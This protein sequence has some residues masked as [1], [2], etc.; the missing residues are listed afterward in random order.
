MSFLFAASHLPAVRARSPRADA[1]NDDDARTAEGARPL[2]RSGGVRACSHLPQGTGCFAFE[3]CSRDFVQRVL[4]A[5]RAEA[6][7]SPTAAALL[8]HVARLPGR[9]TVRPCAHGLSRT[10][11]DADGQVTL[12]L[13]PQRMTGATIS[14]ELGHVLQQAHAHAA[15]QQARRGGR[16]AQGRDYAAAMH[17]GRTALDAVVPVADARDAGPEHKENEAMRISNIVNAERTAS[18]MRSLP[19]ARRTGAEF[20]RRQHRHECAPRHQHN[21]HPLPHG[22][23]YGAYDFDFVKQALDGER[24][25]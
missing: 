1:D 12:H 2:P 13:N 5:V 10:E 6:A 21:K 3:G 24:P 15:L 14:H 4:Q 19:Q 23:S 25:V 22:S 11:T 8:A 18:G 16:Q 7:G 20:W 17:S 9:I